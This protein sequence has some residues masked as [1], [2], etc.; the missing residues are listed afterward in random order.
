MRK[1]QRLS[2][3]LGVICVLFI[4]AGCVSGNDGGITWWTPVSLAIAGIFGLLSYITTPEET[5]NQ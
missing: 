1:N 4:F 2:D 5:K 3:A